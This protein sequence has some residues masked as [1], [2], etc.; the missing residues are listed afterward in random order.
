M[1]KS[2]K[3][4]IL[5]ML[6]LTVANVSAFCQY[7]ETPYDN[8][9]KTKLDALGIKYEITS[10]GNFKIIFKM[11]NE[12]T[13]L[14]IINSV[15]YQYGNIEVREIYSRAAYVASKTAF[16]QSNLFYILQE[17]AEKK[18]GAWQIDGTDDFSLNFSLRASANA[19]QSN[20]E[21]MINLAAKVADAMEQKLTDEDK[22]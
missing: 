1:T 18:I 21:D 8:R 3:Q 19:T 11:E 2:T 22:N 16:N 9:V 5:T 12:R 14:V 13:Q 10:K 17:N 15:T 20:L 4:I 7:G 6:F